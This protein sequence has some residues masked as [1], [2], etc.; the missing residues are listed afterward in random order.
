M[1]QQNKAVD[2][3]KRAVDGYWNGTY[4]DTQAAGLAAAMMQEDDPVAFAQ[5]LSQL[6][7]TIIARGRD[8]LQ[9]AC[10]CAAEG[11]TDARAARMPD[12]A[13]PARG[14]LIACCEAAFQGVMGYT[15]TAAWAS[16]FV[17]SASPEMLEAEVVDALLYI[18]AL[19]RKALR[20]QCCRAGRR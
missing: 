5:A 11:A 10:A 19:G 1:D 9:Q 4:G 15:Q 8:A 18:K 7:K 2:A 20:W 6:L 13:Q 14:T 17:Q 16:A 3:L 12:P